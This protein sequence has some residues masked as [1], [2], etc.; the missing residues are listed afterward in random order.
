MKNIE[1]LALDVCAYPTC[2][3]LGK[4]IDAI[5]KQIAITNLCSIRFNIDQ[6]EHVN[7][8]LAQKNDLEERYAYHAAHL[9]IMQANVF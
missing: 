9:A 6:S 7:K 4:H 8:L 5:N 3:L 1:T 2:K